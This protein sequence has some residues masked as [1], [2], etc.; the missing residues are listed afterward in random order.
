MLRDSTF[1]RIT[2]ILHVVAEVLPELVNELRLHRWYHTQLMCRLRA[3]AMARGR[4]ILSG[5]R[6]AVRVGNGTSANQPQGHIL[7][8]TNCVSRLI[9]SSSRSEEL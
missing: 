5:A 2:L 8:E 1:E 9:E 6:T 4:S 3:Q 7:S